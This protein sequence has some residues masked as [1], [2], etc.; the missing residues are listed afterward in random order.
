M[1]PYVLLNQLANA[2]ALSAVYVK[3]GRR[4]PLEVSPETRNARELES[5]YRSAISYRV[6]SASVESFTVDGRVLF[7]SEGDALEVGE[8]KYKITREPS[9]SRYWNWRYIRPGSRIEFY[10]K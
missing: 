5:E 10:T 1:N 9:T 7:P 6:W 2:N 3:A 4:I 8:Q